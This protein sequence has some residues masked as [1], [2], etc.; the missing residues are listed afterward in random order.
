M[1]KRNLLKSMPQKRNILEAFFEDHE[2]PIK[3][4]EIVKVLVDSE[5]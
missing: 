5:K 4:Y 3:D 2:G 1:T